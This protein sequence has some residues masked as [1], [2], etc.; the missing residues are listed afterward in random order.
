MKKIRFITILK[1]EFLIEYI[2]QI[3]NT[4]LFNIYF[5]NNFIII[6]TF[7]NIF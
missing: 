5:I 7:K 3:I 2:H 1:I 4:K 6:K